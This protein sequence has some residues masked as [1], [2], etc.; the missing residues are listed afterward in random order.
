MTDS[1]HV[2]LPTKTSLNTFQRGNRKED[3]SSINP[4]KSLICRQLHPFKKCSVG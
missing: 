2:N 1:L 3:L 4:L